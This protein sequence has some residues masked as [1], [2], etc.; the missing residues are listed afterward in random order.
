[1]TAVAL[2]LV[3]TEWLAQA[4]DV[5][6]VD[7][8]TTSEYVQGHIPGAL[9]L[10]LAT[11][12]EERDGV[13]NLLK[14]RDEALKALAQ[15]GID[16]RRQIVIYSG[17]F[18]PIE[19]KYAT[20]LFWILEYLGYPRVAILDGGYA[21]WTREER[22]MEPG[23][24]AVTPVTMPG[25]EPRPEILAD[26]KE[27]SALVSG[28][29]EG[30]LADLRPKP[31]YDG[32]EKHKS[33]RRKGHIRTATSVPGP[34]FL[35]EPDRT[36]KP[37]AELQTMLKGNGIAKDTPLITYCNSGASATIGYFVC[38]VAGHDNVAVYD[39]SMAEWSIHKRKQ[40]E[41]SGR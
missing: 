23:R 40:I 2:L 26:L 13:V 8:R 20:R 31:F 38:R 17:M 11:L 15:A 30:V 34:G 29:K 36:F 24:Y 28:S 35:T 9:H 16:P 39:G 14:P 33:V 4:Q 18:E 10:N 19:I 27:V 7:V 6:I 1:M 3:S 12:S 41:K 32:N 5:L 37:V 21:K 25:L 22:P